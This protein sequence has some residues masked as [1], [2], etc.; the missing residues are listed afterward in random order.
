[1]RLCMVG[2]LVA[3]VDDQDAIVGEPTRVGD[4]FDHDRMHL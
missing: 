1:M 3:S 2:L 4:R